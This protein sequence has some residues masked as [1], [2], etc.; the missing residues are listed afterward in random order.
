V[1]LAAFQTFEVIKSMQN[2]F[3]SEML[4]HGNLPAKNIK[5][6]KETITVQHLCRCSST[7]FIVEPLIYFRV[8]HGTPINKTLKNMNYL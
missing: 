4:Q 7:F 3:T 1:A 5:H 6:N 2:K 8:C